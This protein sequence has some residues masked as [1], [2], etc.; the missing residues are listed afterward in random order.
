MIDWKKDK[1]KIKKRLRNGYGKA[2][3]QR[4]ERTNQVKIYYRGGNS[5]YF[6]HKQIDRV[7]KEFTQ[8][9]FVF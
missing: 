2:S 8:Y 4:I 6:W 1:A 7:L 5:D 3:I 9:T